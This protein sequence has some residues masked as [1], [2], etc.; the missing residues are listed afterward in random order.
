[1]LGEFAFVKHL[2][3]N[4]SQGFFFLAFEGYLSD[5]VAKGLQI[6]CLNCKG[7]K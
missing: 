2:Y 7:K 1:M 5:E 3:F 6:V 4:N